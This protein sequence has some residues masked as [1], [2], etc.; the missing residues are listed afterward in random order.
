MS[1]MRR[2]CLTVS[3]DGT[4]YAGWQRQNNANAIENVLDAAI[5]ELTGEDIKVIGA[6]RTDAGVHSAGNIAVFDTESTIPAEKFAPAVNSKLPDD[7][8]I[9]K[10]RQVP[11]SF[12][13]RHANTIKTY[14]YTICNSQYRLPQL[15]LYAWHLPKKLDVDK[16]R[17]AAGYLIGTHDFRAFASVHLSASTTV[18]TIY[19]LEIYDDEPMIVIRVTGNG[20]LYNMVRIIAGTLAQVGMGMIPPEEVLHMLESHDRQKAG[21]TAPP[22]GLTQI[23]V[24]YPDG[25]DLM[26]G[27]R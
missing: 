12:H 16:M 15:R 6:S 5:K 2:I 18:R 4:N 17:A 10:S 21:M 1:E 24:Q 11:N 8:A 13:P 19:E 25:E 3:Y 27:E 7:I 26:P 22:Q 14:E 9:Q 23:E 20:F